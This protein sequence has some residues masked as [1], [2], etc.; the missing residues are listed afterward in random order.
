MRSHFGVGVNIVLAMR[1]EYSIS[2][3]LRT[4]SAPRSAGPMEDATKCG[5]T[6][7][8][9]EH[10][11]WRRKWNVFWP[12]PSAGS[13][14]AER[15]ANGGCHGVWSHVGCGREHCV[16]RRGRN[17]PL[18]PASGRVPPRGARGGWR[19]PRS[20]VGHCGRGREHGVWRRKWNVFLTQAVG[21]VPPRGARGLMEDAAEFV[22]TLGAGVNTL[23]MATRL[24]HSISPGLR[25]GSAPRS[26]G[27]MED[28][29]ACGR[30]LG[31]RA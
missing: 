25:P 18:A 10:C 24:E 22:R 7:R 14:P 17:I 2:P 5:R 12:R 15:G 9:R 1:L 3:G 11:A 30:T 23:C 26:A 20:V 6:M 16:S 29:T 31:V 19:T 21:R 4:G 8:G 28:D 13:T 27:R